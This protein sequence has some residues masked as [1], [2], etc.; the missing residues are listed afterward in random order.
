MKLKLKAHPGVI[1]TAVLIPP[2]EWAEIGDVQD[3]PDEIAHDLLGKHPNLFAVDGAKAPSKDDKVVESS[4]N[5][6]IASSPAN[7]GQPTPAK[8]KVEL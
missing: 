7:K 2:Y 6:V 5:K 1:K 3:V 8:P 4:D